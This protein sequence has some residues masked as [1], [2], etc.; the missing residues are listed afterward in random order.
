MHHG[1]PGLHLPG[2]NWGLVWTDL[3]WIRAILGFLP[4]WLPL[5]PKSNVLFHHMGKKRIWPTESYSSPPGFIFLLGNVI[6]A[7]SPKH[8]KLKYITLAL[9]WNNSA[10]IFCGKLLNIPLFLLVSSLLI[11]SLL[12]KGEKKSNGAL[13]SFYPGPSIELKSK[14]M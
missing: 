14:V 7:N 5:Y 1:K 13:Q 10:N 12:L 4:L 2:M 11:G 9:F 3:K 6:S 8:I